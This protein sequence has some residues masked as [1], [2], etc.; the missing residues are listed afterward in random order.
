MAHHCAGHVAFGIGMG[1]ESTIKKGGGV[2]LLPL[3]V[4]KLML[5]LDRTMDR[6]SRSKNATSSVWTPD[7]SVAPECEKATL[8]PDR[9]K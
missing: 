3:D 2:E 1:E 6:V 9:L 7:C 8:C 5:G 4:H